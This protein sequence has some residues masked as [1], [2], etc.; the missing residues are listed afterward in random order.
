MKVGITGQAGFVGTH[1][2]NTLKLL[3]ETFECVPFED[4]Y[5]SD[6]AALLGFVKSCDAIVHLA[7]VNRMRTR[8]RVDRL[9]DARLALALARTAALKGALLVNYCAV[10][11]LNYENGKVSG[12]TCVD[13]ETQQ[14]FDIKARCVINAAGVWVDALREQDGEAQGKPV[15]PMVWLLAA[16]RVGR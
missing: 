4:A 13:A 11:K 5:F 12:L 16:Y 14:S 9:L 3:P 10:T 1:L 2:Y 8:L 15:K 7:A 6:S